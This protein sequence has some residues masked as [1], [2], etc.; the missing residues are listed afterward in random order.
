MSLFSF[1]SI[2]AKG[3][4]G[5]LMAACLVISPGVA[6]SQTTEGCPEG[7]VSVTKVI[8]GV[9]QVVCEEADGTNQASEGTSG[10]GSL[11]T[12][13]SVIDMETLGIAAAGA[14]IITGAII[15]ASQSDDSGGGDPNPIPEIDA[16]ALPKG[17]FVI[18]VLFLIYGRRRSFYS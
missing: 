9:T 7:Y 13:D 15:L 4:L 17:L 3:P 1:H 18:A 12:Q 2:R 6:L 5:L 16:G 11:A 14:G 8:D 10:D